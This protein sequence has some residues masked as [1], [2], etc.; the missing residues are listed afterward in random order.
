MT[1]ATVTRDPL[2]YDLG[3]LRGDLS[4]DH[5]GTPLHRYVRL[6]ETGRVSASCRRTGRTHDE[7]LGV[8]SSWPVSLTAEP[9]RLAE[10]L[11]GPARELLEAIHA[12][13]IVWRDGATRR[14]ELTDDAA[15][16]SE[17]LAAMLAA[18]FGLPPP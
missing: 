8:A 14:G 9:G 3:C 2:T 10:L 18:E 1:A 7:L 5:S 12:G 11:Q 17:V 13:R 4:C 16:A 6:S 15:A